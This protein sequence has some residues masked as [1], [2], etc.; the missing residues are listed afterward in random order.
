ME[1]AFSSS[2]GLA[3]F[4][5]VNATIGP[6]T[7]W[8]PANDAYRAAEQDILDAFAGAGCKMPEGGLTADQEWRLELAEWFA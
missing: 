4:D 6:W 2:Y 3:A 1:T 7:Q 5:A 8:G